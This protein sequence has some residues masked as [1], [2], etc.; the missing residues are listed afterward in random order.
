MGRSPVIGELSPW[1]GAGLVTVPEPH[2]S[3]PLRAQ[4][5][6]AIRSVGVCPWLESPSVYRLR[7]GADPRWGGADLTGGLPGVGGLETSIGPFLG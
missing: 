4:R 3:G 7:A 1:A 2:G 5:R 6:G